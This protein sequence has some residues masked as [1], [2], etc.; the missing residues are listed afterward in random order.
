MSN[1]HVHNTTL[2]LNWNAFNK[3]QSSTLM[4]ILIHLQVQVELQC[5]R[6]DTHAILL[7]T[8]IYN[9]INIR[10]SSGEQYGHIATTT[11]CKLRTL[12]HINERCK[13]VDLV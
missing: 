8:S 13:C 5:I 3:G 6:C 10:R 7:Q 11:Q 4:I 12:Y 1:I 2:C 9:I